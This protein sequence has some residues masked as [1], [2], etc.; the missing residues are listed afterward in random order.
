MFSAFSV[1][2]HRD[3]SKGKDGDKGYVEADHIPPPGLPEEG[4]TRAKMS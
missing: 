3:F 2:D 1:R 4:C